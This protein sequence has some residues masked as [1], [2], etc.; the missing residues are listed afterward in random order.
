[1]REQGKKECTNELVLS[2][3]LI[4]FIKYSRVRFHNGDA[5]GGQK[6]QLRFVLHCPFIYVI[7]NQMENKLI[8]FTI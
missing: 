2:T 5:A 1:L 6:V 8:Y 3:R 4:G 7:D